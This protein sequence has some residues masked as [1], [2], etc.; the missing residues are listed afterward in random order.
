MR[1]DWSALQSL[2]NR[3]A[4]VLRHS[5]TIRHELDTP[6]RRTYEAEFLPAHLEIIDRPIH[7]APL[8]TMRTISVLALLVVVVALVGHLDVI[9]VANGKLVPNARVKIIQPALTGV[10]RS[11]LVK[12]GMHVSA[13][14]LLLE[15]DPAQAA[16]DTD[17]ASASK[18]DAQLAADRARALLRAQAENKPPSVEPIP[19]ATG[20][21][22]QQIQLYATGIYSE[23]QN[24]LASLRARLDQRQAE[25]SSARDEIEKLKLTAPLAR[26]QAKNYEALA[27]NSYVAKDL[28]LDKEHTAL[29]EEGE[30]RTQTDRAVALAAAVEEQKQEIATTIATFRRE[31]LEDLE[32]AQQSL[33]QSSDDQAKARVRESL[34]RLTAPVAG[35]V[36]NLA[37]HTVGGV[38]TTAQPIL[39]IVPE[40][41][42]EVEARI[43]NK[44]VGFVEAGQEAVIKVEAFPYTRFGYLHGKVLSVSNDAVE[45]RTTGLQYIV[46]VGLPTNQ[47]VV[48]HKNVNLTPGMQVVAEI[49]TGRRSVAE[50]FFSPLVETVGQSMRER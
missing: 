40:D 44:D 21:R 12:N 47:M 26:Q 43:D 15:L 39:E 33:T 25:L 20:D 34:M 27:S 8:W 7:P 17:K 14:Q 13:G 35:T 24:R 31:Q 18:L 49:R 5:W 32:R 48:G 1:T 28:Y 4:E 36:Q 9:A 11:I 16:A 46:R 41:T 42:L 50:Y 23:Y 30:L 6:P 3:Y 19:G 38:V 10:V 22:Q 29:Q 37:I 45:T 2:F